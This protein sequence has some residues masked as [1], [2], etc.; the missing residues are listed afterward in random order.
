[1]T[2]KTIITPVAAITFA[3]TGAIATPQV[4]ADTLYEDSY[5]SVTGGSSYNRGRYVD[6]T[7]FGKGRFGGGVIRDRNT[8]KIYD[9]TTQGK[10]Y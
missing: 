10:C 9:C 3:L 4:K 1:M 8:G 6:D 5:G 7:R 2:F